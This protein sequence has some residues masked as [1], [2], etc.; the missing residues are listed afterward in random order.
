MILKCLVYFVFLV[1]AACGESKSYNPDQ[2]VENKKINKESTESC[3]F[4]L[5]ELQEK[6]FLSHLDKNWESFGEKQIKNCSEEQNKFLTLMSATVFE[7]FKGLGIK[8]INENKNYPQWVLKMSDLDHCRPKNLT[9]Q[10][11]KDILNC[12]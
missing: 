4:K 5:T 7:S 10:S 6:L 8:K 9:V 3:S 2:S 1:F 12:Q 11:L